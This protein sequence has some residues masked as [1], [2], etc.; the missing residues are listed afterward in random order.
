MIVP[1]RK[2]PSNYDLACRAFEREYGYSVRKA[3]QPTAKWLCGW[4]IGYAAGKRAARRRVQ[5]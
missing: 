1:K 3:R 2:G 5:L 4:L